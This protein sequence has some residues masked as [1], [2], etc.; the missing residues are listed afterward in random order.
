V[1]VSSGRDLVAADLRD[2]PSMLAN[3]AQDWNNPTSFNRIT[4]ENLFQ[5]LDALHKVGILG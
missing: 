2:I 3:I 5:H 4:A 1:D